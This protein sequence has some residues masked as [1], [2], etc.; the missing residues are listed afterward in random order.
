[1][2][3]NRAASSAA[4]QECNSRQ[5]R[6]IHFSQCLLEQR[7][8]PTILLPLERRASVL[9]DDEPQPKMTNAVNRDQS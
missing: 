9:Q 6:F 3:S 7:A 1:M 5:A 8:D 4:L 2:R